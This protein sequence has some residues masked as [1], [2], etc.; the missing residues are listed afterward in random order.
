MMN[1]NSMKI[2]SA[3]SRG[4]SR[5][6]IPTQAASLDELFKDLLFYHCCKI[7]LEFKKVD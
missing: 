5:R 7:K 3:K 6:K 4:A 2:T 1:N